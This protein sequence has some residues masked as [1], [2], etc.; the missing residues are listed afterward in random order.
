[1]DL[2][3]LR[4]F[5]EVARE[6]S[7]SKAATRLHRTQPAVSQAIRRLEDELGERLFDRTAKDGRLTEAGRVLFDYAERLMRLAEEADGAVRELRDLRRGRVLVG[8]NEAAT[9]AL[10]P[11]VA[12]FRHVHPRVQV[13][14]RRIPS[15]Q[16]GAE[17]LQRSLDFGVLSFVP[18]ERRFVTE[19]LLAGP[20]DAP[21]MDSLAVAHPPEKEAALDK[22]YP[23][24]RGLRAAWKKAAARP[25]GSFD[26]NEIFRPSEQVLVY[27]LTYIHSPD[28]RMTH[29]LLGSDDGVRVWLNDGLVHSNPAYR[30][31]SVDEDRVKVRLHKGWNKLLIKV[32][33]GAGGW[34]FSLRLADPDGVLRFATEP[35]Q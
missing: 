8:A 20:F 3:E 10:L 22:T 15:R 5:L 1:M 23:G 24:K 34:G 26:L 32:V 21:D 28:D 30:S 9:H 33:Q 25:D 17:V 14:V 18:A 6:H 31:H 27:G 7:F 29:I 11:I 2:A 12:R 16:I 4:V 35:E 19:W 13:D